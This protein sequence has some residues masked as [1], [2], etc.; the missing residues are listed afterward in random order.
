MLQATDAGSPDKEASSEGPA[1]SGR[2]APSG[3][4]NSI[5]RKLETISA[6]SLAV[7]SRIAARPASTRLMDAME[8]EGELACIKSRNRGFSAAMGGVVRID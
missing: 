4:F 3:P 5:E 2:A 7:A 1:T 6:G 8:R